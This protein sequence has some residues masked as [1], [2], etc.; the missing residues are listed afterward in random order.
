MPDMTL[1]EALQTDQVKS[2]LSG[3]IEDA[4]Q[5]RLPDAVKDA[6]EEQLPA[7][8]ESVREEIRKDNEVTDLHV[9]ASRLI[10]AARLPEDAKSIL[11]ADYGLTEKGETVTPGRALALVEAVVEDG[12]VTKTAKQVLRESIEQDVQRQRKVAGNARPSIPVAPGGGSDGGTLQES[13]VDAADDPV[14]AALREK[15]LNPEQFGFAKPDEPTTA[16]S[17]AA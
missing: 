9:E 14:Q 13:P 6:V 15:G 3:L 4:V 16:A 7:L 12:K 17:A 11:R 2:V 1:L 8:R 5:E 10:E